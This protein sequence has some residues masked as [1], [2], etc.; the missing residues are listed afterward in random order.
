MHCYKDRTRRQ[1]HDFMALHRAVSD[2]TSGMVGAREGLSG[3]RNLK[4]NHGEEIS[5]KESK[6]WLLCGKYLAEE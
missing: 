2:H 3:E 1:V 5:R 4:E 6:F